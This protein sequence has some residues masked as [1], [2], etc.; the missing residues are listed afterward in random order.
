MFELPDLFIFWV[1]GLKI[2]GPRGWMHPNSSVKKLSHETVKTQFFLLVWHTHNQGC[3]GPWKPC[4]TFIW[5]FQNIIFQFCITYFT[6]SVKGWEKKNQNFPYMDSLKWSNYHLIIKKKV[7]DFFYINKEILHWFEFNS[8]CSIFVP[9][10][11]T[12]DYFYKPVE[13]QTHRLNLEKRK[14]TINN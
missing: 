3:L 9:I 7:S 14:I 6:A 5:I 4:M 12:R 8:S 13:Y 11:K 2:G 1:I 10:P